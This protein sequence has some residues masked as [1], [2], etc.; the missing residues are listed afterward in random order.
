MS[1]DIV[2]D[3]AQFEKQRVRYTNFAEKDEK[4]KKTVSMRKTIF[5][6]NFHVFYSRGIFCR[7][8]KYFL[9]TQV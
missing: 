7:K 9:K 1:N 4:N 3:W 6:K 5:Q 2:V 8:C